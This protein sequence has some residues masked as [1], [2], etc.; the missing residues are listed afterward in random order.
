MASGKHMGKV[1]LQVREKETDEWTLPVGVV[2]RVYCD[3]KLVYVICGG[4]G[5]FGLELA[6]WLIIRGCRKLVLS[7]SRGLTKSYQEF[8]IRV[9]K[10]Y[11]VD[12][13]V[14]TADITTKQGCEELIIQANKM[15]NVGGVFNLA[16]ALRDAIFENQSSTKFKECMAPKALATKYLDEVTRKMCPTLHQFVVFS[17]VSCGRGNAGQSNYGMAN[18][19]MERIMER[20][21]RQ[22]L[23]GKAIQVRLIGCS[24]FRTHIEI[25]YTHT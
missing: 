15:G 7:S 12:I 1:L 11:G 9:W 2:P 8:R 5:G 17:S 23:C 21:N 3:A 14:S 13:Q 18:S 24:F 20:R 6:D 4:L 16:V 22:G 10:M 25:N 19:V